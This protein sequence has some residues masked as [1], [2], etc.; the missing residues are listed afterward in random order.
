MRVI[1]AGIIGRYPWGGVTWCSLMYLLGL[2][3]LGHDVY[4]LE[5]TC[6][7]NY[8][9]D[10]NAIATDPKYAL[11][12]IHRSLAPFGFGDRWCYVDYQ[13]NHHGVSRE[14][15]EAICR[16][17]DLFLVLSGG[18]WVWR[19]HYLQIPAKV[20]VDSDPAF[21]QHAIREAVQAYERD[22]KKRWYVDFFRTYDRLFTFGNNI[23]TPRSD[24]P[25]AGFRWL[26]TWQPIDINVWSPLLGP[27]PA[28]PE[29]T[30][31]T[32][33]VIK[34]FEDIGGY[35]DKEF[36]KVL[37]LPNRCREA[38]G[39]TIE[40]AVNGPRDFL[41]K[42]GWRCVDAFAVSSDAWRYHGYLSSSRGEFGVAKHTYVRSNCGWFSDRTECYLALGRPAVVQETGFSQVLPTGAGLL[43]WRTVDEAF[44]ALMRVESDY[45]RHAETARAIAV[46]HFED[47]RVLTA[48][49]ERCG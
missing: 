4:Y 20:F 11:D 3:K 1:F 2:H 41:R 37:G 43:L 36:L 12:Y 6:E 21:T 8:D 22:E 35:K 17:A 25:T 32:T 30:T 15:W 40:L 9:P 28:R 48:L 16:S 29:W 31:V 18:C 7:C 27:M 14:R 23:G 5:D 47:R 42:Q 10:I 49:L 45:R 38:G 39:P 13:G 44:D 24:V 26:P 34:S 33:W 46:E 19:D